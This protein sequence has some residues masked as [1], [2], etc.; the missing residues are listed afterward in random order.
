[1]EE[2]KEIDYKNYHYEIL[3]KFSQMETLI[4]YYICTYFFKEK[5]QKINF[6]NLVTHSISS[7]NILTIFENILN[8]EGKELPYSKNEIN[9]ISKMRNN[10]AHSYFV[11]TNNSNLKK[12]INI[13]KINHNGN[14]N[15]GFSFRIQINEIIECIK[16][17]DEVIFN[18]NEMN[19]Y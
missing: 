9:K 17:L 2:N 5:E 11:P 16:I 8:L 1:M 12:E 14:S 7:K 18:V 6:T 19:T 13:T 10:F 4:N 3:T 15:D